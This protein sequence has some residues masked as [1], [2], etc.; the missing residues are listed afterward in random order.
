MERVIEPDACRRSAKQPVIA[1]N[2]RQILRASCS[3]APPSRRDREVFELDALAIEHP[4]NVM[5]RRDEE[6][7]R[8]GEGLVVGVPL[9]IGVT[10]R[11]DDGQI[12]DRRIECATQVPLHRV[13][14]EQAIGVQRKWDHGQSWGRVDC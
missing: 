11:A 3:T 9:R 4:E 5:V 12:L 1:A 14:G 8:V 7:G 10:M 13:G 2:V 6:R